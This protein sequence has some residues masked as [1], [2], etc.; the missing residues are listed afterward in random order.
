MAEKDEK[1]KADLQQQ[2]EEAQ[3]TVQSARTRNRQDTRRLGQVPSDQQA[4]RAD[5]TL[6]RQIH[7]GGNLAQQLR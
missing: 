2:L 5:T 3:Q 4:V 7:D 1:N 6:A